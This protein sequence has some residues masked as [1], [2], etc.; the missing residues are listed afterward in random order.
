MHIKVESIDQYNRYFHQ[1]TFHPLVSVAHLN[2]ADL[3][4][5]EPT[6]FGMYCVV[7]MEADFGELMLRNNIMRYRAGTIFTMNH[8]FVQKGFKQY[9]IEVITPHP[10]EKQYIHQKLCDEVELG[11][12]SKDCIDGMK[13]IA[14]RLIQEEKVDGII[15]GCTEL[16]LVF[17]YID[18]PVEKLDMMKIHIDALLE[19]MLEEN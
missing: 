13:K 1:P 9:D 3:S 17:E 5:F 2:K 18:L 11:I 7:L 14:D 6:D 19:V 8:D 12:V 4:L 16:P 15:L 10:E